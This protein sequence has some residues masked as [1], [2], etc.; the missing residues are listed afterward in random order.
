MRAVLENF[1]SIFGFCKI[2]SHHS[3]PSL[4]SI[5]LLSLSGVLTV[6]VYKELTGNPEIGNTLV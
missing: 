2:T 3:G 5:L 4:M 1:S 6:S